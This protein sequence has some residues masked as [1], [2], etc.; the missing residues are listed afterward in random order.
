MSS[1]GLSFTG[2]LPV[3]VKYQTISNSSIRAQTKS[4]LYDPYIKQNTHML[5]CI[6]KNLHDK[7]F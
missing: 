6:L 2:T 1:N 3:K 5:K 4:V 7:D